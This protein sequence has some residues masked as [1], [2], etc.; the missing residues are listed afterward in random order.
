MFAKLHETTT[1]LEKDTNEWS[2]YI[3]VSGKEYELINC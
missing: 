2:P 3:Y 1:A